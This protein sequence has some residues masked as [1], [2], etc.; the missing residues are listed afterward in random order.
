MLPLLM[1]IQGLGTQNRV[2]QQRKSPGNQFYNNRESESWLFRV[3][4][5]GNVIK[6]QTERKTYS[7]YVWSLSLPLRRGM[8][9]APQCGCVCFGG[10]RHTELARTLAGAPPARG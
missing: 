9:V 5:Q 2:M 4:S 3:S 8:P 1:W 6:C 7:T 10:W